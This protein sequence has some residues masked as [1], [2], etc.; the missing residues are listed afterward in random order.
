MRILV[1]NDDGVYS[2]GLHELARALV[3]VGEVTVAAVWALVDTAMGESG[4]IIT[5]M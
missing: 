3:D 5:Y 4:N 2:V 1:T